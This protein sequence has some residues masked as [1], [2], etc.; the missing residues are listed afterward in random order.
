M[1]L[2]IAWN[3]ASLLTMSPVIKCPATRGRGGARPSPSI[4]GARYAVFMCVVSLVPR[5][6][7]RNVLRV[8]ERDYVCTT[9]ATRVLHF[10]AV[11]V[12]IVRIV[13]ESSRG[14]LHKW[15]SCSKP[16]RVTLTLLF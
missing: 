4:I 14:N 3:V 16:V 12:S 6:S 11:H 5:P 2:Y 10:S 15:S 9:I 8:W 13:L 7:V 1:Q